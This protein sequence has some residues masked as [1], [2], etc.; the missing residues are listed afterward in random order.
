MPNILT[1]FQS[2]KFVYKIIED[3][4]N[5][6]CYEERVNNYIMWNRSQPIEQYALQNNTGYP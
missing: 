5:L 1:L 4:H 2:K 6:D 3:P